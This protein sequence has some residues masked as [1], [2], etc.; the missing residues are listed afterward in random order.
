MICAGVTAVVCFCAGLTASWVWSTPV[1]AS[2][3]AANLTVF[4]ASCL[5]AFLRS[6]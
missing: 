5:A 6:R 4:L 3:V 2:V 1:G